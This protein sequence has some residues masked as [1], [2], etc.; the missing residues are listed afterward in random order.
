MNAAVG[1]MKKKLMGWCPLKKVESSVDYAVF[2]GYA[3]SSRA[4]MY[5]NPATSMDIPV[6]SMHEWRMIAFLLGFIALV[7]IGSQRAGT[8]GYMLP[9]FLVYIALVFIS[10]R[11]KVSVEN[12]T[13]KISKLFSRSVTIPENSINSMEIIENI[14]SRHKFR[15][16][17]GLI[18]TFMMLV[19]LASTFEGPIWINLFIISIFLFV[20]TLFFS[21]RI[22]NNTKIIKVNAGGREILLYPR[23]EHEFPL[24]LRISGK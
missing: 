5:Y 10:G 13:L 1:H 3:H 20:Y 15:N 21:I 18:L 7:L 9:S 22:Y 23:S 16:L 12:G 24:L 11:T 6:Q 2:P 4:P 14:A 19:F 17:A 8:F